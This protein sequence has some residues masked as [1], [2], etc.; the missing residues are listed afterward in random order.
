MHTRT[1]THTYAFILSGQ[2]IDRLLFELNG[3]RVFMFVTF[4]FFL[5]LFI[6]ML[7]CQLRRYIRFPKGEES[8]ST[9]R[10]I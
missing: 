8:D 5:S 6:F 10:F 9:K 7:A 3:W 1:R 4:I 2:I